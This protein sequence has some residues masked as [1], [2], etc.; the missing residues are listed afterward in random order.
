MSIKG[1]R[2]S[3]RWA[4]IESLDMF[5]E[6]LHH[7]DWFITPSVLSGPSAIYCAANIGHRLNCH[8]FTHLMKIHRQSRRLG[9]MR[10]SYLRFFLI[11]LLGV[12]GLPTPLKLWLRKGNLYWQ[13]DN[14][15]VCVASVRRALSI[16]W[17][18]AGSLFSEYVCSWQFT[19][20]QIDQLLLLERS[21]VY[22][23]RFR[24]VNLRLSPRGES[25]HRRLTSRI[26]SGD[27]DI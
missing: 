7:E 3:R 4:S 13:S 18:T 17:Y 12:M 26:A 20:S 1:L 14:Y 10:F 22:K 8:M 24:V 9:W 19:A 5:V 6:N 25:R 21:N 27:N 11:A 15:S 2:R 23:H 16:Q